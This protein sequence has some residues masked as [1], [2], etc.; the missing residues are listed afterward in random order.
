M[1]FINLICVLTVIFLFGC[2]QASML[3]KMTPPEGESVAKNYINLL[4]QNSFEQIE[5]DLDQSIKS[6][7]IRNMMVKMA[8][9]IPTREPDSIKVV[10]SHVFHGPKVSTTNITFEYQFQQ[11]WLLINVAT[12]KKDGVSTIVGFNVNPIPDSMENINKFSLIGKSSLH[13]TVLVLAVIIPLFSLFALVLCIRT[14]IEKRKWLWVIFVM[15]GI[16]CFSIDWTTGQWGFLPINIQFLGAGAFA[17][18]YGPWRIGISLP[19]GAI[20]FML[21]RKKLSMQ[22]NDTDNTGEF[23]QKSCEK[24]DWLGKKRPLDQA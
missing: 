22:Q 20:I 3:K 9:M 16:T 14:K 7:D 23:V 6:P 13:Y 24:E 18:A 11:K 12:Q 19:L 17:P 5:K 2:D 21:K 4:R 15:F 8:E 10:G 1:R